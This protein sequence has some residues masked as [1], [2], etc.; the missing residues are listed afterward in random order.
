MTTTTIPIKIDPDAA[1]Y[2]AAHG[3]Q[4]PFEEIL[5]HLRRHVPD[6]RSIDVTLPILYDE[7]N[8]CRLL[9]EAVR[10][11]SDAGN[12]LTDTQMG[13]WMI[14]T[15]PPEVCTHVCILIYELPEHAR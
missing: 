5:A 10:G 12:A 2:V 9:I 4:G 7:G 15:F 13:V 11:E 6:V 1:A 14:E 3:L 8:A